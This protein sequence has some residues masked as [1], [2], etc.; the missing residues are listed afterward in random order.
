MATQEQAQS[1]GLRA[2][3]DG[4]QAGVEER[5]RAMLTAEGGPLIE[6]VALRLGWRFVRQRGSHRVFAR[7]GNAR[8]VTIP[9]HCEISDG[10]LRSI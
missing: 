9:G 1:A 10:T 4:D 2:L 5:L 8:P 7:D 3:K 6:S